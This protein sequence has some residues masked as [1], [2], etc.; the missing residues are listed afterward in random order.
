[1]NN[2][3]MMEFYKNQMNRVNGAMPMF[4]NGGPSS[5]YSSSQMPMNLM[6]GVA[7]GGNLIGRIGGG[8]NGIS[9]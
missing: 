5:D 6:Q 8:G 9:H 2:Q 4:P 7:G 1:M 3:E